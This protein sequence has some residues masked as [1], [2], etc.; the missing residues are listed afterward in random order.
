LLANIGACIGS[1]YPI[2]KTAAYLLVPYLAWV[3]F[4]TALTFNIWQRNKDNKQE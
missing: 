4:A 2:N 1:F 3:S